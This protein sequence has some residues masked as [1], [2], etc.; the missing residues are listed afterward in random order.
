VIR[1][2]ERTARAIAHLKA[3]EFAPFVNFLEVQRQDALEQMALS[4]SDQQ[5]Y[6]L[7]GEVGL[8]KKLL[9]DIANADALLTKLKK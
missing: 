8:L 4:T 1:I 7:Q 9:G 5:I 6:R 2:D 3:P